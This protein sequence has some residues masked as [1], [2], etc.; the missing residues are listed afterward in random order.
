M[1]TTVTVA[2]LMEPPAALH[3]VHLTTSV[4]RVVANEPRSTPNKQPFSC[5]LWNQQ[6]HP[7][8]IPFIEQ[9]SHA[10]AL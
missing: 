3:A 8:R 4:C 7:D 5:T 6:L 9:P 10:L 2:A 1:N